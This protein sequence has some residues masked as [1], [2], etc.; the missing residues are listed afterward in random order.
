MIVRTLQAVILASLVAGCNGDGGSPAPRATLSAPYAFGLA[1]Q[2]WTISYSPGMPPTPAQEGAG[3]A[4][5][6]PQ[7]PAVP[8]TSSV[9][10][11]TRYVGAALPAAASLSAEVVVTEQ[12]A[13]V[14][15][16]KL[17]PENVCDN[18]A[19]FSLFLQRPGDDMTG[20][21]KYEFY[22]WWSV[23]D[24]KIAPGAGTLTVSLSDPGR[25]LS[26]FGK[27]GDAAPAE[28]A[29]AIADVGNIGMTFGG[30]CFKGHGVN[31]TPGSG[32]SR[33]ALQG[34]RLQ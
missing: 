11:V 28:F 21:G 33:F 31:L 27:R 16:Y 30:G 7:G 4:F 15:Q 32:T 2:E 17:Q 29:A 19:G 26:V 6:F 1:A 10:Y 9:H 22:R 20:T 25:W 13:P 34:F 18:P 24:Y 14:Y 5:D 12:G 8:G 3:W 23:G